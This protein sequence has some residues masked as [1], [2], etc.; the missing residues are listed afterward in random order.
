M[1]ARL[2]GLAQARLAEV[3]VGTDLAEGRAQVAPQ[4]VD[5]RPVLVRLPKVN[6]VDDGPGKPVGIER[7]IS[8]RPIMA[9]GNSDGDY[10]MLEW[11]TKSPSTHPRFGLIVHHTDAE[12]EYARSLQNALG[13]PEA[14]AEWYARPEHSLQA[15]TPE[16]VK[17]W[18]DAGGTLSCQGSFSIFGALAGSLF[19]A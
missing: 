1:V 14:V 17:A 3:P 15:A 2:P 12:R 8:R 7:F 16:Q 5:G 4:L 10:E 6:F 9:F 13:T 18:V 11:T 19:G